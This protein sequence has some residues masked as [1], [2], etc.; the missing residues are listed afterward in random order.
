M[1]SLKVPHIDKSNRHLEFQTCNQPGEL[2]CTFPLKTFRQTAARWDRCCGKNWWSSEPGGDPSPGKV[3][4]DLGRLGRFHLTWDICKTHHL[5][6]GLGRKKSEWHCGSEEAHLTFCPAKLKQLKN[7]S[8]NN[9][10]VFPKN[11][12][13][14]ELEQKCTMVHYK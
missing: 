11:L 5:I 2:V 1:I 14:S 6:W 8:R 7:K 4:S 9:S 3:L 13:L 10:T 12:H